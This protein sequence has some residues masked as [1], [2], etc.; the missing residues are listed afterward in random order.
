MSTKHDFGGDKNLSLRG[1]VLTAI[2]AVTSLLSVSYLWK[3]EGILTFVLV[4]IAFAMLSIAK[5]KNEIILFV[6]CSFAGALAESYAILFGVWSY[7]APTFIGIPIWLP[8]LW[9]IA[10]VFIKR[11]HDAI[12]QKSGFRG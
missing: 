1:A 11:S 12:C 7:S 6:F 4:A 9:G 3:N 8:L 5:S 10:A 2:L